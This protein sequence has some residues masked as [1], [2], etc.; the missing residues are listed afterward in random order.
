MLI[1]PGGIQTRPPGAPKPYNRL[2]S[3]DLKTQGSLQ[4]IV[5]GVDGEDEPRLAGAFFLGPPLPLNGQLYVLAEVKGE[6]SLVVLDANNG[7][8][9][10]S[11]QLAHV[12]TRTITRD[13]TRRLAGATPS[14]SDGVLVCPT[15]AGAVVAVDIS[16][17]FLLCGYRY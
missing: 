14:Y 9:S 1:R 15:S 13:S 6:I 7:Q 5:G 12:D 11:Q 4:W 2:V 10:W 3:L 16:T 8:L 17:H